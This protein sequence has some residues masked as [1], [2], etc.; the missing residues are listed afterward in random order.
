MLGP[1]VLLAAKPPAKQTSST[2]QGVSF[3][4][5]KASAVRTLP[6]GVR[7]GGLACPAA[8][9]ELNEQKIGEVKALGGLGKNA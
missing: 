7:S 8:R 9:Y 2:G 4:S 6:G 5:P 3:P 1:E